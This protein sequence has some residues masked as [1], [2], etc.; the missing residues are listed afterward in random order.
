MKSQR[1]LLIEELV[2]LSVLDG[3]YEQL[4]C[5]S[6]PDSNKRGAFSL[7]FRAFDRLEGK[8]VAIKFFDPSSDFMRD[9]YRLNAFAR[10]PEILQQLL[11]KRRCLQLVA[12]MKTYFLKIPTQNGTAIAT[13]ACDYFVA[14]WIPNE[15]DSF[16]ECQHEVSAEEKLLLFN[17]IVLAVE[18]LHR[19][20]V[21]HRD[22]KA[23]NLRSY[24]DALKRVVIAIDL[25]T[26]ALC[27]TAPITDT[28][29]YPQPIGH[30]QYS[31]PEAY[32]GLAIDREIG[33]YTD[34]YALGCLLFELFNKEL[35]AAQLH[36]DMH[37]IQALGALSVILNMHASLAQKVNAW[38]QNACI[39]R[40]S[41][42]P[43]KIAS[44]GH[45]VPP[46]IQDR[47]NS[48]L[49]DLTA[50]DYQQR[51]LNLEDV[52]ERLWSMIRV[53]RN[54]QAQ[55]RALELKRLYRENRIRKI[56]QR[57]QRLTERLTNSR[58]L[59]C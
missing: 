58:R 26:A 42:M 9:T 57:E 18:G 8:L 30:K 23:N 49:V 39:L 37:F 46:E 28:S 4:C 10:E 34:V 13:F 43:V 40:T 29:E 27:D 50:F 38:K 59:L 35:F 47:L 41:I 25:G 56:K 5:V 44:D 20:E 15:I 51:V 45:S 32:C 55:Q 19:H 48:L 22:I 6:S 31:S 53:V 33:R 17:E 12:G 52:R 21:F 36:K 1:E 54:R 2:N 24:E 11:G 3:R 16:F 7:V 14:D